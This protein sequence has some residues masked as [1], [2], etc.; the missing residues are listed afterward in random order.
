MEIKAAGHVKETVCHI[1]ELGSG[2]S[3]LNTADIRCLH[4]KTILN[5]IRNVLLSEFPCV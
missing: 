5:D 4:F 3:E 2:N 1:M